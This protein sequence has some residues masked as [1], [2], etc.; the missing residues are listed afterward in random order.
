M[1][2]AAL[3]KFNSINYMLQHFIAFYNIIL[4]DIDKSWF[5]L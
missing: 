2:K 1:I 4:L 3:F 5:W